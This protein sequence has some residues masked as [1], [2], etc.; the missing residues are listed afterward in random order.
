MDLGYMPQPPHG[1]QAWPAWM[2]RPIASEYLRHVHGVAAA[3]S[4][5]AKYAVQGSGP[6]FEKRGRY[7]VYSP[8]QLDAWA[9]KRYGS[10]CTK[11]V[12]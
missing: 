10:H 6:Q 4:S 11:P 5:L 8:A 1:R 2:R 9:A 3:P 12:Q 7:P